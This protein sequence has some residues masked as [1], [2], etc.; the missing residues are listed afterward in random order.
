M[1]D[2]PLIADLNSNRGRRQQQ[3]DDSLIKIHKKRIDYH[4]KVGESIWIKEYEPGKMKPRLHE[5]YPIA[6][7]YTNGTVGINTSPTTID[8]YNIRRIHP[9]KNLVE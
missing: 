7:V 9:Y 5:L 4:Y 1:M 3:I 6:Q 2:V 8:K